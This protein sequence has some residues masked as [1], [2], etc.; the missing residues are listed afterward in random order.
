ML[1]H[2]KPPGIFP[3][4]AWMVFPHSMI[5]IFPF[6]TFPINSYLHPWMFC[7]CFSSFH[8]YSHSTIEWI[9]FWFDETWPWK[10][11]MYKKV[12][13]PQYQVSLLFHKSILWW[14]SLWCIWKRPIELVYSMES[15]ERFAWSYV[16]CY[17]TNLIFFARHKYIQKKIVEEMHCIF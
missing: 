17:P 8:W 11:R 1:F 3:S 10:S 16:H 15:Y 6:I 2:Q 4:V 7:E 5:A 12:H 13:I 9:C 14:P